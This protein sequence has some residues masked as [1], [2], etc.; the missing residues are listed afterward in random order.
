MSSD[1]DFVPLSVQELQEY[2]PQYEILTFIA[3]GGMGAVYLANQK[4]IDRKVAIKVL[5]R[6]LSSNA[7]FSTQFRDE[8]KV[9]SRVNHPNL[10][11]F[12]DL[13]EVDG[14]LYIIMEFVDGKS[15]HHSAHGQ[16]IAPDVALELITGI[17]EGIVHAHEAGILHRD[18]KPANILLDQKAT[19]KIGDFGLARPVE[20]SEAGKIVFGTPGYT[21]PEVVNHPEL[22]DERSD[23]FSVGVLFY[24]LLAGHLPKEV[25]ESPRAQGNLPS[26]VDA[27]IQRAIAPDPTQRYATSAEFLSDLK[28]LEPAITNPDYQK[29]VPLTAQ[30]NPFATPPRSGVTSA[31]TLSARPATTSAQ[32]S[33]TPPAAP[34]PAK[35]SS[36][37]VIVA[38]VVGLALL[39]AG[40]MLLMKK[41]EKEVTDVITPTAVEIAPTMVEDTP[42]EEV[43]PSTLQQL[44]TLREA[45][46]QQ[47]FTTLPT[48]AVRAGKKAFLFI[49]RKLSWQNAH[50][51]AERHGGY[52]ACP[53]T[54]A[55]S[56]VFYDKMASNDSTEVW[57]GG[58]AHQDVRV[59]WIDG[60]K[61]HYPNVKPTATG[62]VALK[63]TGDFKIYN[64]DQLL[65]FFICWDLKGLQQGSLDSQLNRVSAIAAGQSKAPLPPNAL[66]VD[67]H[68]YFLYL[69]RDMHAASK[70]FIAER[71]VL[72]GVPHNAQVLDLLQSTMQS[73]ADRVET[74]WLGG[75]VAPNG[76]VKWNSPAASDLQLSGAAEPGHGVVFTPDGTLSSQAKLTAADSTLLQWKVAKK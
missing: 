62:K 40:A 7:Q 61:W 48:D 24:E 33:Y 70:R 44:E 56:E 42:V 13:G 68:I 30:A 74:V 14:M 10:V 76:S 64:A 17:T 38:G 1:L 75:E 71:K 2:F 73:Y 67:D 3:A 72:P 46:N 59:S 37:G 55:Y 51:F 23:I 11:G 20:E 6:E 25:Y 19:P 63:N 36:S 54:I 12:F 5:P 69:K 16:A 35:K 32:S 52:L 47:D 49:D 31:P 39:G 27:V 22:I 21:A 41:P 65:P 34:A 53:S 26:K 15:L 45:L 18:I 60:E 58:G 43:V 50:G 9:M 28:A 4:S 8:A 57:T 29:T 66:Q